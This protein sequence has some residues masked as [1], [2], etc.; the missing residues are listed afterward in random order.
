MIALVERECGREL[1]ECM[2][3][4]SEVVFFFMCCCCSLCVCG[5]DDDNSLR[6]ITL[7]IGVRSMVIASITLRD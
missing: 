6:E 5:D 2:G 4:V 7:S 3:D 1:M